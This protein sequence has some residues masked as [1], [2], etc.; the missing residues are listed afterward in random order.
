MRDADDR[1]VAALLGCG[2]GRRRTSLRLDQVMDEPERRRDEGPRQSRGRV[3]PGCARLQSTA[4]FQHPCLG[5]GYCVDRT[6]SRISVYISFSCVKG[7]KIPALRYKTHIPVKVSL[8]S[9]EIGHIA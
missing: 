7:K 9:L 1:E 5:H 8:S 6:Y 2:G 3:Q 4:S